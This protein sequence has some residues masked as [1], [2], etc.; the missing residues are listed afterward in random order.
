M[1][2]TLRVTIP[3]LSVIAIALCLI[4]TSEARLQSEP[5]PYITGSTGGD[6]GPQMAPPFNIQD[7][8]LH[9]QGNLITTIHNFGLVGGL[10]GNGVPSG[11]WP[12]NSG[13][14]YLA[15]IK[16][17]MGAVTAGGDTLVANTDDDFRGMAIPELSPSGLEGP[18]I[19]LSTDSTRYWDWNP[20]DTTGEASG[21]AANGWRVWD[22]DQQEM[23]YQDNFNPFDSTF[24]KGGAIGVQQSHYLFNDAN[25]GRPLL[26]LELTHTVLQWNYCYNEDFLFFVIEITNNSDEDYHD[27]AFGLYVD[28]DV[29]GPAA[30]GEGNGRL[31][32]LVAYDADQNLAWTYDA[33]GYDPGWGPEVETGIM[34]TKYLETPD[35]IGM[36]AFRS[37]EWDLLPEFDAGRYELISSEQFDESYEPYDQ[38]YIQCTRGINLEAG[39]TVRVVYALIAGEDEADFRANADLAQELYDNHFIGPEPP[40]TPTLRVEA[41]DERAYVYWDDAAQDGALDPFSGERDFGGYKLYRSDDRGM[42]WGDPIHWTGNSCHSE[43]Y[44]AVAQWTAIGVTDLMPSTYIDTGLTNGVEYWYSVVAFDTGSAELGV[45]ALQTAYGFPGVSTNA[46]R[47]VPRTDPAGSYESA[48]TVR[49]DYTGE[50]EPSDGDCLPTVFNDAELVGA[51]YEVTFVDALEDTYWYLVNKTTGDTVLADQTDYPSDPN[52]FEVIDG[53]RVVMRNED[54]VPRLA[55]Q[56]TI[57]GGNENMVLWA[58][59]GTALPAIT[60]NPADV[61]GDQHFR[62]TYEVRYTGDSTLAPSIYEGFGWADPACWIPFEVW[63]VRTNE[64]VSLSVLEPDFSYDGVWQPW[65]AMA[66]VNYP[67]DPSQDLTAEA[68]PY[69]FSWLFAFDY[70][71]LAPSVGDVFTIVG[72]RLNS[73][74][75]V[76]TFSVDGINKAQAKADLAN[77]KVVPDPYYATSTGAYNTWEDQEGENILQFQNLPAKCTIRIYTLAGDHIRTLENTDGSGTIAWDMLTDGQRLIASGIYIY[78]L[79]S[80][81]GERLGRFAV[82][83]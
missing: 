39:K 64:R 41:G 36:T 62:T 2:K 25:L 47:I 76:F 37:G 81:Y 58:W 34:G 14:D 63:N 10:S 35:G 42:T 61:F 6:D 23:V 82:V 9:S 21:N 74:D 17:W 26:G 79:E 8:I 29:G 1:K 53:L 33:D 50:F 44:K 70:T 77:V 51:D 43:D 7:V 5:T 71:T 80:E 13:H 20:A 11:R 75:D 73:P 57:A 83:K 48:G 45:D 31:G 27:F 56:T 16:Y 52:L 38:Y 66:I 67:Y 19:L 28:L 60:K 68:F 59:Y 69:Y 4:S 15:E 24:F 40:P 78:H 18:S 3:I 54:L 55:E 46:V 65:E 32:D 30:G 49:H 22:P 72:P 12:A